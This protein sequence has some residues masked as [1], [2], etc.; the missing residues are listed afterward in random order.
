M[1]Q[2]VVMSMI[3]VALLSVACQR[4]GAPPKPT[5]S[6]LA[7]AVTMGMPHQA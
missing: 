4:K 7:P 5:V 2:A 3:V 6:L 1:R